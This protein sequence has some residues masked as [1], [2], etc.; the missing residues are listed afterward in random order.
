[1]W[2]TDNKAD[3]SEQKKYCQILSV[4]FSVLRLCSTDDKMINKCR[5]VDGM[6]I[7]RENPAAAV[8]NWR[9]NV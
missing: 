6:R 3:S 8:G 7:G 4:C 1:L 5:A 9:L 2:I